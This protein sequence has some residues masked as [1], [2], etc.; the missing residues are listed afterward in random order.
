MRKAQGEQT[1]NTGKGETTE[2]T[3]DE[4]EI[5]AV[6]QQTLLKVTRYA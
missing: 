2:N 6:P 3:R 4:G 1:G 5:L